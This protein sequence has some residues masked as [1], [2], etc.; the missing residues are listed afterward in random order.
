M[1]R[2]LAGA[3]EPHGR[4][5]SSRLAGALAPHP[6]TTIVCGPLRV[7]YSGPPLA[8]GEPLCLLDGHIDNAAQLGLELGCAL[9]ASPER[10]LALGYRRWG[11]QLV[12]RL[13]GDFMLLIWDCE[14]KE[15]LLARDQ[16]G[17]RSLFLHDL[18]GGVIFAGE[19]RQLLALLP[20]APAPDR[21]GVAHWITMSGRSGPGT[22][23]E[24]IRRL[25]PGSLLLLTRAGV[26]EQ[27]YWGPRFAD[28]LNVS[29]L[30]LAERVGESIGVAVGRRLDAGGATGVLMSGG[31]DSSSVAAVAAARSPAGAVLA[32][33]AEFPDHP[34]IDESKQIDLLRSSLG[35]A[36][37][38]AEVRPGG[39]LGGALEWIDSWKLPLT[40]WGEFWAGPLLSAASSAGVGT[41]LGGDGG[42][43]L[44]DCRAYLMADR[45]RAGHPG[46]ALALARELP[47][48]E[49]LS[50]R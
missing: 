12:E 17:V 41:V 39:L 27:R 35:L 43:E 50:R 36:G 26:R 47:G 1:T 14:R 9:D 7:A 6:S 3:F 49:M 42:D 30:E 28:P 31:L 25:N 8:K 13:R 33:S 21:I 19:I 45:L 10:L 38:T 23:Y 24:G 34:A 46:D 16:L 32:Y 18:A 37:A 15:G 22:L 40:S 29:Q 4:I 44:F 20:R 48:A 5:D 11:P 2:W